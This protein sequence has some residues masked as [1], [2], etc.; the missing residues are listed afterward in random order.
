MKGRPL[1]CERCAARFGCGVDDPQG[2]WC[3]AVPLD[4]VLLAALRRDFGDCLCAAC[5]QE[6]AA[7]EKAGAGE[8]GRPGK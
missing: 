8:P 1:T 2:C 6:L 4:A 3:R 7:K 5:L